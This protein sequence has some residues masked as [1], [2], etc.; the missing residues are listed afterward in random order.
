MRVLITG[1]AGS[2]GSNLAD[3]LLRKAHRVVGVDCT[4]C[5]SNNRVSV[6]CAFS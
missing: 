2:K 5:K 4:E 1:S 3:R 6:E